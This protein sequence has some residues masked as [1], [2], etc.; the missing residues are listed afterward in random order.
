MTE[1]GHTLLAE[2]VGTPST[3]LPSSTGEA[4]HNT[5]A[6][7]NAL[8]SWAQAGLR[9]GSGDQS[10]IQARARSLDEIVAS[11]PT[12]GRAVCSKHDP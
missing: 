6:D 4:H 5:A 12:V 11:R 1:L 10:V 3:Y 2:G 8:S 7:S 9:F